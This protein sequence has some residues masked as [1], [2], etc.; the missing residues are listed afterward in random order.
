MFHIRNNVRF[1]KKII[2]LKIKYLK[3][4]QT[5]LKRI[6]IINSNQNQLKIYLMVILLSMKTMV[7]KTN[8]FFFLMMIIWF[9]FKNIIK[10]II[11]AQKIHISF[12][13]LFK[14]SQSAD[15]EQSTNS[16]V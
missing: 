10:E 3:L 6:M 14:S 12:K 11:N 15:K 2:L 1:K 9:S 4:C 7:T 5:F 16:I 13:I 8:Y